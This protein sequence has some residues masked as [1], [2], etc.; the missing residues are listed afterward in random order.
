MYVFIIELPRQGSN[1]QH[2][3]PKTAVLPIELQGN[4]FNYYDNAICFIAIVGLTGFEPATFCSQ[5]RRATKLR[6]NPLI[7]DWIW[8]SSNPPDLL[9]AEI[10][11]IPITYDGD[12]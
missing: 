4:I 2:A 11:V 7:E 10:D 8:L 5:S 3:V 6:H 12:S 1:L 9:F